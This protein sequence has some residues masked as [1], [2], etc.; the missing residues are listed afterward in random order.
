[1]TSVVEWSDNERGE[2]TLRVW[3]SMEREHEYARHALD[4][5]GWW[6]YASLFACVVIIP[7]AL[8]IP[9]LIY[10]MRKSSQHQQNASDIADGVADGSAFPWR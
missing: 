7:L 2:F 5:M 1:M 10:W 9:F 8:T 3:A 6:M 4:R